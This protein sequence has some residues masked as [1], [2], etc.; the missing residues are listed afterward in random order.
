LVTDHAGQPPA[1]LTIELVQ[2]TDL[3]SYLD[4]RRQ[5]LARQLTA[6]Q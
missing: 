3:A 5:L 4:G 1:R 2:V 6:L